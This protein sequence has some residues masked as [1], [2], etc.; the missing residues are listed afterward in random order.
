MFY[1]IDLKSF[2][3][4]VILLYLFFFCMP[5]VVLCSK[6]VEFEFCLFSKFAAFIIQICL[7]SH[8]IQTCNNLFCV[9]NFSLFSI[10]SFHIFFKDLFKNSALMIKFCNTEHIGRTFYL[11]NDR[12]VYVLL[13]FC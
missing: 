8:K 9:L 4:C 2:Y 13:W 7:T 11:F 6:V 3:S 5:F 12:F 10:L 1:C